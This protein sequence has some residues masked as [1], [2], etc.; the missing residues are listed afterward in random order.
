MNRPV[1]AGGLALSAALLLAACSADPAPGNAPGPSVPAT[2]AAPA[3]PVLPASPAPPAP[4]VAPS[5]SSVSSRPLGVI[6]PSPKLVAPLAASASS[7]VYRATL[8][9]YLRMSSTRFATSTSVDETRRTYAFDAAGMSTYFVGLAAPGAAAALRAGTRT[10]APDA[11]QWASF[12]SARR[13]APGPWTTVAAAGQLRPGDFLAITPSKGFGGAVLIAAGSPQLLS[14]GTYAL[15][16]FD[17]VRTPHGP[18]DT[19]LSDRRA[20]SRSGLGNGT[21]RL[22]TDAAGR[23]T[24]ITWAMD[25]SGPALGG[26]RVVVGRA[27]G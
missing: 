20:R 26:S 25:R 13:G 9:A 24:S 27:A 23:L 22:H 8:L 5:S 7:P 10:S 19:R 11:R 15:R 4:T 2:S 6:A 3:A 21:V 12:L 16:V 17:S 18:R 14:D 1:R